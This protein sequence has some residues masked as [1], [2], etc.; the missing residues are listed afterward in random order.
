MEKNVYLIRWYGPFKTPKE[1]KEFEN[2]H[3]HTFKCSLYLLH[4][5][6]KHAKSREHYYCGMSEREIFARLRDKGHHIEEIKDRLN[7]IYVGRISNVKRLNSECIRL[8]ENIITAVLANEVG[9]KQIL[10]KIN[11]YYPNTNVYVINEWWDKDAIYIRERHPSNAPSHIVPDVIS[12]H[13]D[14]TKNEYSL[15]GCKKLKRVE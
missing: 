14:E 4:G 8:A 2:E 13:Y 6:L 12:Y 3:E 1:V 10:N 15:F 7:S 11:M 5:K 9:D